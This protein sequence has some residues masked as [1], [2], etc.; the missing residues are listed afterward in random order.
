M[1]PFVG[2]DDVAFRRDNSRS[3]LAGPAVS[4]T[5]ASC[6]ACVLDRDYLT[7]PAAE[8]RRIKPTM[9]GGRV[10]LEQTRQ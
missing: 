4:P 6:S 8:I 2:V 1:T 3:E 9:V 10:V 5:A 7:V